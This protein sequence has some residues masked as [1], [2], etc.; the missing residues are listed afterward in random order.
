MTNR[1][2]G[3]SLV[4]RYLCHLRKPVS[5]TTLGHPKGLF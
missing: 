2:E 3:E 5:A 4:C 1:E